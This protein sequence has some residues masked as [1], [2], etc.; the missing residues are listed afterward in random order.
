[1]HKHTVK[2]PPAPPPT[3]RA[4][5]EALVTRAAA[6]CCPGAD[7]GALVK[8]LVSAGFLN[9]CDLVGMSR[10][11]A[12]HI[13]PVLSACSDGFV[14]LLIQYG[15]KADSREALCPPA[16]QQQGQETQVS[17]PSAPRGSADAATEPIVDA[18]VVQAGRCALQVLSRA[19]E[20]RVIPGPTDLASAISALSRLDHFPGDVAVETP[21]SEAKRARTE[22]RSPHDYAEHAIW[23]EFAGWRK[24]APQ[25]ASAIRLWGQAASIAG[26][27][28]WPPCDA[29]LH[30]FVRLFRNGASLQRYMS[31]VRAVCRLLQI[32]V[33]ALADTERLVKG[34]EKLT[35]DSARR[36]KVRATG[37]ETRQL[38]R[39]TKHAGYPLLAE[40]WVITRHFCLRYV[41]L[42]RLGS[43]SV[44]FSFS[45][46]DRKECTI[47]FLHRKCFKEP[48]AV[49][50]RC[51]C[52]Q[53][54]RTLCGVCS[55]ADVS[56]EEGKPFAHVQYPEAL[57]VLK[58]AAGALKLR[59]PESWGTHAFRRGFAEEAIKAG[60][61]TALFYSGGWRGVA[62]F[63]YASAQSRG[64]MAAA[65]WL[66]DHSDSSSAAEP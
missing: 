1:M 59:E 61:P 27:N 38:H 28:C 62:A 34:A 11:E 56:A 55:L 53:Q 18:A 12:K 21:L 51:I 37:V 47:T 19:K 30:V 10:E 32:P 26:S 23:V 14:E 5:L 60:G 42:I 33:A 52:S 58:M 9:P 57:A 3:T 25:Y 65:E 45:G 4:A 22:R 66:I 39:W 29:A 8:G 63:G 41:E 44:S 16:S 2:K 6:R 46:G 20:T 35:P 36:L 31:H 64:A 40:S 15:N 50:R 7:T 24:S 48:V 13:V 49:V 43:K 54:G 17:I